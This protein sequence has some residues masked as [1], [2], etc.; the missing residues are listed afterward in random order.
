MSAVCRRRRF[1]SS[2][3]HWN[4][5]L[6]TIRR[7]GSVRVRQLGHLLRSCQGLSRG[8]RPHALVIVHWCRVSRVRSSR[9]RWASARTSIHAGRYRVSFTRVLVVLVSATRAR[10]TRLGR[11][12][13]PV[14]GHRAS[15][16]IGVVSGS[17]LARGNSTRGIDMASLDSVLWYLDNFS[18]STLLSV[19]P[20]R[21]GSVDRGQRLEHLLVE[22]GLVGVDGCGV[23]AQIVETGECLAAMAREWSLAG[24]FAEF[25]QYHA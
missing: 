21:Q 6:S 3:V 16:A 10:T 14:G 19:R 17:H 9:G 5:Q 23:L 20:L 7:H 4:R 8:G 15:V 2:V 22:L 1:G 12:N 24:V 25:S 11:S 13:V 18:A